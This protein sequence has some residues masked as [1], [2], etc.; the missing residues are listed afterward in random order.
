MNWE[1]IPFMFTRGSISSTQHNSRYPA[2]ETTP[3][4]TLTTPTAA[5][6]RI[7][8]K[9]LGTFHVRKPLRLSGRWLTCAPVCLD[10][11][12]YGFQGAIVTEGS[13]KT[14][15]HLN[16]WAPIGNPVLRASHDAALRRLGSWTGWL[17]LVTWVT[18]DRQKMDLHNPG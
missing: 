6:V 18:A 4:P 2:T 1:P 9:Q 16:M 14:K 17:R 15:V 12:S 10:E 7:F 3:T 8:D 13:R 5:M 11:E